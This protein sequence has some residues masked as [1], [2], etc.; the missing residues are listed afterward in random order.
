MKQYLKN[1]E[2]KIKKAQLRLKSSQKRLPNLPKSIDIMSDEDLGKFEEF[3]SRFGRLTDIFMA[4]YLRARVQ[5]GDPAFRGT[6]RDV[7]DYSEKMNLIDSADEWYLIR[8]LRNKMA[9]EY[10]EEDLLAIFQ[11][12][13]QS[14][15][16]IDSISNALMTK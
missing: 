4:Q 16:R 5:E 14:M 13:L 11:K 9:H 12:A 1:L 3:L 6:L 7:L 15:N 2:E 10:E 8:E